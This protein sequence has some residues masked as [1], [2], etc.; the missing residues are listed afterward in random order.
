MACQICRAE[1]LYTQKIIQKGEIDIFM[2]NKK[3]ITILLIIKILYMETENLRMR[4][5]L[6]YKDQISFVKDLRTGTPLGE[7]TNL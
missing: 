5:L 1:E 3:S 4:I 6:T 2:C 7:P